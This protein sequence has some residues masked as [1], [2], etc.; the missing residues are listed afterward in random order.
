[1]K[2]EIINL[3]D[4][5]EEIVNNGGKIPFSNKVTIDKEEALS[6]LNEMRMR[7]PD[8]IKLAQGVMEDK[9][10]I[11][12]SAQQEAKELIEDAEREKED[13]I[14]ETEIMKAATAKAQE[15]VAV[16]TRRSNEMNIGA[17]NYV[18]GMLEEFQEYLKEKLREL[19][20]N[21]KSLKK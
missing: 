1:M 6:V 12:L 4:V 2:V 11:I 14:N 3:I 8:D 9:Q 18:D 5:L 13:M 17:V 10:K 19:D 20:E 7:L 15:T 16:A 21:R